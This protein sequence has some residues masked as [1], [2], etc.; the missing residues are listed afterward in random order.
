[1]RDSSPPRLNRSC[2]APMSMTASGPPPA[3]MLPAT[4]TGTRRTPTCNSSSAATS[5]GRPSACA[6]AA[7]RKTVAGANS[8][9]R[10]A[11]G[12]RCGIRPGA[13]AGSASASAP[14]TRR[15]TGAAFASVAGNALAT[16]SSTGAAR[17]TCGAA[18]ASAYNPSGKLPWRA[19]SC[20][21]GWPPAARVARVNSCSAEA[22]IRCTAN[23]SATPSITAAAATRLRPGW[24]RRS[25]QERV[26]NRPAMR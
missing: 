24:R 10:S 19:R 4:C 1:M 18:A 13:K 15:R 8:A 20:T 25:C 2:A 6:A 26:R 7:F 23:A 22:L 11:P 12:A 9:S 21:S 17:A 3:V 14:I 16:T 5:N